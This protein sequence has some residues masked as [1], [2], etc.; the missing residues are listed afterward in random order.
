LATLDAVYLEGTR[1]ALAAGGQ[2][3]LLV[4]DDVTM[5]AL[6][7]PMRQAGVPDPDGLDGGLVDP[8]LLP[9]A[10]LRLLL[11]AGCGLLLIR[12]IPWRALPSGIGPLATTPAA[13][14]AVPASSSGPGPEPAP[15]RAARARLWA[16]AAAGWPA[17][18]REV[19]WLDYT[20]DDRWGAADQRSGAAFAAKLRTLFA[21]VR[22]VPVV[23]GGREGTAR[24]LVTSHRPLPPGA[25][26]GLRMPP[27]GVALAMGHPSL[28]AELSG[29]LGGGWHVGQVFDCDVAD[30]APAES[31]PVQ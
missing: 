22:R 26:D 21:T 16:Q 11:A 19:A 17:G 12:G 31:G 8:G 18:D 14:A 30:L 4:A 13:V 20:G 15:W 27:G 6:R 10:W 23:P 29:W 1:A 25:L 7:A 2:P 5:G 28:A 9:A 3:P 24:L